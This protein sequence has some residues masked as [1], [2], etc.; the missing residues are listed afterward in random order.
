MEHT[1]ETLAEVIE[2]KTKKHWDDEQTPYLLADVV[3]DIVKEGFDYKQLISP[4]TLKQFTAGMSGKVKVIQHPFLKAK[5]GLIP[6]DKDFSY[7][8]QPVISPKQAAKDEIVAR[9]NFRSNKFV[10]LNFLQALSAL[11]D[12][13]LEKV[14]I[15]A[16]VLA[17]LL[18][19]K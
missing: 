13:D 15:P 8:Q 10:V 12:E 2:K 14:V 1:Q 6:A 4:L 3:P 17:K 18:K 16:T 19:E 11:S 5:V 7:D 9:G